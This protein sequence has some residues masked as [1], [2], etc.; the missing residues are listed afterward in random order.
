MEWGH[1]ESV[2]PGEGAPDLLIVHRPTHP[3]DK[4]NRSSLVSLSH[5]D[6]CRPV[7]L[8]FVEALVPEVDLENGIIRITPPEG[9]LDLGSLKETAVEREFNSN[10]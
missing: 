1:V 10:R 3:K 6:D 4:C 5:M 7:L 2:Y 8:P 9:L